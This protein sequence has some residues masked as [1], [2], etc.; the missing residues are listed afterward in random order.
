M[1]ERMKAC[2]IGTDSFKICVSGAAL[3]EVPKDLQD[4][5]FEL[6]YQ[7]AKQGGVL[8]TGATIGVPFYAAKG[9]K[10]AGGLS[11]G[12]SPA[13]TKREHLGTYRLPLEYMDM[14]IY[15][16]FDY[17]GRNLMLTRAS[18]AVIEVNGRVGTLNEFT[19]AFE[20]HKPIGVL[21]G[22]GGISDEIRHILEV[23]HRGMKEVYF[24]TEPSELVT[25]I[26]GVL[27][28]KE[29]DLKLHMKHLI[30]E[31]KLSLE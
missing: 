8:L 19:I 12:L 21:E 1:T 14:I 9:C 23:S 5:S 22:T 2:F 30:P 6:G 26:V 29:A 27:R 16:G 10:A 15:T 28:K 18:D 17:S 11:I 24:H 13:S 20:D 31:E 7:I 3:K 4:I 25:E